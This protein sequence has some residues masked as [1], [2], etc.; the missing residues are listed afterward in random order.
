MTAKKSCRKIYLI[1]IKRCYYLHYEYI[2]CAYN[3][4]IGHRTNREVI[5]LSM[6]WLLKTIN[7]M[8]FTI[9]KYS[10]E[11]SRFR[12]FEI[13][14]IQDILSWSNLIIK[15]FDFLAKNINIVWYTL[16]YKTA[17]WKI[18]FIV[19]CLYSFELVEKSDLKLAIETP[20]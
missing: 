15:S 10:Y 1:V 16:S 14:D 9:S 7:Q 2:T 3:K 11:V 8:F 12:A 6:I 4:N 13:F 20:W 18:Y 19:I 17:H 5:M